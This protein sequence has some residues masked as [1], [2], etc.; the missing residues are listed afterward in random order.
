MSSQGTTDLLLVVGIAQVDAMFQ[1]Q[2]EGPAIDDSEFMPLVEVVLNAFEADG[3][4]QEVVEELWEYAFDV[5]DRMCKEVEPDSPSE[6][7]R[8]LMQGYLLKRHPGSP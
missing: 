4:D 3:I 8:R 6:E 5:Y 1:R 2:S 7:D